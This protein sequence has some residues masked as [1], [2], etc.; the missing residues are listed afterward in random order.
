[1]SG[2]YRP[3]RAVP[4]VGEDITHLP[5]HARTAAES[6]A[7]SRIL[8]CSATMSVL[9]NVLVGSS[10]ALPGPAAAGAHSGP[11]AN[12]PRKRERRQEAL[13]ILD[14]V[15]LA[16]Y[17]QQQANSLP[18]GHQRL[19]E[20]ARA[21]ACRP[22]LLLLDEPGAGLNSSELDFLLLLI[23]KR[24]TPWASRSF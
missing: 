18:F 7:R 6:A 2:I 14:F 9:D 10:C 17:A 5:A 1:M 4:F 3:S 23:G 24:A 13:A 12:G 20:I 15:G 16:L 22:K 11:G 8:I 21:L 19:L